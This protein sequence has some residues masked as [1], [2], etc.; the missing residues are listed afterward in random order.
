MDRDQIVERLRYLTAMVEEQQ[1]R[2]AELEQDMELRGGSR[3]RW[4]EEA[5]AND[6]ADIREAFARI[7]IGPDLGILASPPIPENEEPWS[8]TPIHDPNGG[9][10]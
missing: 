2:I 6:F 8:P 10:R 1:R 7:S 5:D 4:L 9:R 3:A